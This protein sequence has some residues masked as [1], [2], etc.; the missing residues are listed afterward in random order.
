MAEPARTATPAGAV[1][2]EM[3]ELLALCQGDAMNALRV[4]LIANAFLEAEIDR[5]VAARSP[6][7]T[8]SS[9]G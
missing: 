6:G 8:P 7:W 9:L 3:Q 1:E 5:L 4:V 2:S